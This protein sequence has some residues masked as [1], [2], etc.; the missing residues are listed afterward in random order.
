MARFIQ[1]TPA[2][3]RKLLFVLGIL[4]LLL[5]GGIVI[6]QFFFSAGIV[7]EWV[8]E[9]ELQTAGFNIYRSTSSTEPFVQIN[10]VMIPSQGSERSGSRY[11]YRDQEVQ[12]G[13]IYFYKLEEVENDNSLQMF[14]IGSNSDPILDWWA[15][16]LAA[17][18][19]SVGL[20]LLVTSFKQEKNVWVENNM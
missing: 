2:I 20:F 7:V 13:Q 1:L 19:I 8:T 17:V 6:S 15:L 3:S 18:S 5:G 16:L 9:T 4:W 12:P 14:D 11:Q 10:K